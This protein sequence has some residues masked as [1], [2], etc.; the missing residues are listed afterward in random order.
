MINSRTGQ[1]IELVTTLAKGDTAGQ[2]LLNKIIDKL[3]ALDQEISAS[4]QVQHGQMEDN[5]RDLIENSNDLFCIHALDGKLLSVNRAATRM[6]GYSQE[7]LLKMN[8][9][10]L[11]VPDMRSSFDEYLD[12]I[13][14]NG[15]AKGFMAVVTSLGEKRIWEYNNTLRVSGVQVPIIR[16]MAQ[17]IT[18]RKEAEEKLQRSEFILAEAQRIA[19]IGSWEVDFINGK[20]IWSEEMYNIY[21]CDP[22]T[23]TP[24]ADSFL[25]LLHPDDREA[26]GNIIAGMTAG[27]RQPPIKFRVQNADGSIK[28]IQGH[29]E[30]FFNKAGKPVRAIGTAQDITELK[31]IKDALRQSELQIRKYAQHLNNVLEEERAHLSRE[32]HDELGQRLV[33]IKIGLLPFSNLPN[34]GTGNKEKAGK[35]MN[36]I[37]DLINLL[38][39]ISTRLRPGILD[40]LGLIPS[41]EWLVKEFE[42][43]SGIEC[44]LILNCY[45]EEKFEKNI[46]ITFFR[47]CQEALTNISKHAGATKIII[48]VNRKKEELV[49]S[50]SDNGKGI[51]DTTLENPFSMGLLGMKERAAIIGA[52]LSIIG[53]KNKGTTVLLNVKIN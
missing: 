51:A 23:F 33:G 17:D 47:I 50:V 49:L 25:Q 20:L 53:E 7:E 30:I 19:K 16:G 31:K 46:S 13:R 28:H 44:E 45:P 1:I 39:K 27:I 48:E 4:A 29:G 24:A 38:R 5:C 8:L 9:R 14:Q 12:S 6:L 42:K 37:D 36:E 22:L 32:I 15:Y 2:G 41:I 52:Q 40:S 43:K 18:D 10:D 21:N 3:Y 34:S 11:I 35:M 26:M